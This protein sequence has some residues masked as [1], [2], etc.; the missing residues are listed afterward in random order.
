MMLDASSKFR[1]ANSVKF[2]ELVASQGLDD[3]EELGHFLH[4]LLGSWS[5]SHDESLV[6]RNQ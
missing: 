6:G 1:Q 3:E 4:K 5:C 2:G